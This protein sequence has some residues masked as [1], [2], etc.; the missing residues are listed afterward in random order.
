LYN[1]QNTIKHMTVTNLKGN[2]FSRNTSDKTQG[3]TIIL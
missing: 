1:E 2:N 3:Y